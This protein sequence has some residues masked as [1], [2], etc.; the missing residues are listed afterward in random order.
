MMFGDGEGDVDGEGAYA[1]QLTE[2]AEEHEELQTVRSS[3]PLI[4]DVANVYGEC[5][6]GEHSL[7][8]YARL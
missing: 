3:V 8:Q 1:G 4:L 5:D 7:I 6:S 2:A